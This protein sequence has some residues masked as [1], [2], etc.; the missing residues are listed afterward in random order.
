MDC[1][2]VEFFPEVAGI[3]TFDKEKHAKIKELCDR[4]VKEVGVEDPDVTTNQFDR[5]LT[6]YFNRSNSSLLDFSD[7]FSDF[8]VWLKECCTHFMTKVHNYIIENGNEVIITDCW[9][10]KTLERAT[11]VDHN[12]HN[13]MISGTYYVNKEEWVHS[14][15]DFHKKRYEMHP[16][17]SHLKN[18][19]SPNK[20]CRYVENIQPKEGQLVLWLSHLYHGYDGSTNF[21][22]DRT[23]ISMNFLPKIIDNGKYSFRIQDNKNGAK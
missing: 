10:N 17:I 23:S 5:N 6:H 20:Y 16:H 15:L 12:H 22:A 1:E 8:E 2:L 4:V 11:Q 13:A 21:W 7:E 9:M 14:G 19:D 3:Y 18:W